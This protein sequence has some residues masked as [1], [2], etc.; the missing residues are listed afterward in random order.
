MIARLSALVES[1]NGVREVH[2]MRSRNVGPGLQLDLH[3]LVDP[4]L[5]VKEGHDIAN[6]VT[7]RL[8]DQDPD[9]VD[10]LVHI[11]PYDT[12]STAS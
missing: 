8:L 5:T 7:E 10:V 3:V 12:E 4:G 9:V 2:G 1:T 11:E 6:V